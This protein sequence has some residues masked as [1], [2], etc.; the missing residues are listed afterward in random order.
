MM[1]RSF[2]I[3]HKRINSVAESIKKIMFVSVSFFWHPPFIYKCIFEW[4]FMFASKENDFLQ[5]SHVYIYLSW[6]MMCCIK[7]VL[8]RKYLSQMSLANLCSFLLCFPKKSLEIK[9]FWHILQK[10]KFVSVSEIF[11]C[12]FLCAFKLNM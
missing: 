8:S 2:Y 12:I 1:K 3:Y 10:Y 11:S 9:L 6:S 5:I 4:A 7:L